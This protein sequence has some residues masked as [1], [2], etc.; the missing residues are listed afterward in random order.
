[1]HR[2]MWCVVKDRNMGPHCV[3]LLPQYRDLC[4]AGGVCDA[5]RFSARGI[6]DSGKSIVLV[7]GTWAAPLCGHSHTPASRPRTLL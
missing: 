6:L 1:M 7:P 4:L 5:S 3:L 2:V